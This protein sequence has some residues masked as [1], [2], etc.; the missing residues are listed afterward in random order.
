MKDIFTKIYDNNYWRGSESVSGT[1]SSLEQTQHLRIELEKLISEFNINSILDIPC[2][3]FHWMK[4]FALIENIKYTGGDI[5]DQIISSNTENYKKDNVDFQVLDITQDQLPSCDLIIIRDCLVHFNFDKI[6]ETF[7][8]LKNQNYKYALIT[9]FT[10]RES[11]PEIDQIGE[12]RPLN[13]Q[14]PPFK[15]TEPLKVINEK[16]TENNG[17]YNDKSMCLW[18]KEDLNELIFNKISP[19]NLGI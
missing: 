12:W 16:C 14:K 3:D 6:E 5:V 7:N 15:L 18:S 10:Q 13:L 1:G 19:L 8:N 4:N 17:D 11:N 2:G 9:S